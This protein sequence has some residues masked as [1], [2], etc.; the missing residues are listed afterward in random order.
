MKLL[1]LSFDLIKVIVKVNWYFTLLYMLLKWAIF[2]FSKR[3]I[4]NVKELCKNKKKM[5]FSSYVILSVYTF[6]IIVK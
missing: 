1:S 6:Y 4:Q 3:A 5:D 2:N